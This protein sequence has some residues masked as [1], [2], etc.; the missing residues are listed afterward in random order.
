MSEI[1]TTVENYVSESELKKIEEARA[2]FHDEQNLSSDEES[3]VKAVM[4]RV[5]E[6]KKLLKSLSKNE[7]IKAIV[8]YELQLEQIQLLQNLKKEQT[9]EQNSNPTL[10]DDNSNISSS[11]EETE[12]HQANNE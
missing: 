9:D 10:N 8:H 11:A 3:M 1:K 2:Q 5:R 7:L 4:E 6:R 12:K